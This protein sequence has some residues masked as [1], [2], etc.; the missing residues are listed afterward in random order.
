MA[1]VPWLALEITEQKWEGVLTL[2]K[3]VYEYRG[4]CFTKRKQDPYARIEQPWKKKNQT[5]L[6]HQAETRKYHSTVF[7]HLPDLTIMRKDRIKN[8]P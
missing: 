1:L 7:L 3:E 8:S 6:I 2:Q 5:H 4:V